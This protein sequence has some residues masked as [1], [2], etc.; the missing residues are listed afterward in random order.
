MGWR[1]VHL[2]DGRVSWLFY[3]CSFYNLRCA[4]CWAVLYCTKVRCLMLFWEAVCGK[5]FA[6]GGLKLYGIDAFNPYTWASFPWAR[7]RVSGWASEWMGAI[8][9]VSKACRAGRASGWVVLA[10][11]RADERMVRCPA[12]RFHSCSTQGGAMGAKRQVQAKGGGWIVRRLRSARCERCGQGE[13]WSNA[14]G[15]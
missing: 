7:E 2:F 6:H 13:R 14:S 10:F 11:E 9:R 3:P 4:F 15:E 1:A 8:E 5:A 12:R